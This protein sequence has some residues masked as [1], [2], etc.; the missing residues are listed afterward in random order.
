MVCLKNNFLLL[1]CKSIIILFKEDYL[2]QKIE[3]YAL[4]RENFSRFLINELDLLENDRDF[5]SQLENS[6]ENTLIGN[7]KCEN[8]EF[9]VLSIKIY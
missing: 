9:E 8:V 1:F 4:K 3:N 5:R 2:S 7:L 6:I